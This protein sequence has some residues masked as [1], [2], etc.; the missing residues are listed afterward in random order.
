MKTLTGTIAA[1]LAVG[2]IAPLPAALSK[3]GNG[4]VIAKGKI[5]RAH[6]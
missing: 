1:I 4:A 2:V 5:G 6:V 3:G